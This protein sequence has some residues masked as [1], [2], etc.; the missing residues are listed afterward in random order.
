MRRS[1]R[2]IIAIVIAVISLVSY[3][4]AHEYNPVTKETQHVNITPKG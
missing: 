3:Y 1:P 4:T 2:L